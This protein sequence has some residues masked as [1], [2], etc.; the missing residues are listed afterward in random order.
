MHLFRKHI[1]PIAF[2]C[3]AL[4]PAYAADSILT[5]RLVHPDQDILAK[6]TSG[7]KIDKERYELFV[8][9]SENIWVDKKVELDVKDVK[10]ITIRIMSMSNS[11]EEIF[12]PVTI[13]QFN[14]NSHLKGT[15]MNPFSA[16]LTFTKEGQ[17]K[18]QNVTEKNIHRQLAVI[19]NKRLVMAPRIQDKI[20]GDE[21]AISGLTYDEIKSLSDVINNSAK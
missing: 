21:I 3:I 10:S 11:G 5:F 9:D 7:V 17:K 4:S 6:Q 19:V 16:L 2:L 15:S 20:D 8:K 12:E 18:I 14:K 1:L 13:A